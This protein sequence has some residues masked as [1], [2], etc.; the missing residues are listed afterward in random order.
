M[1][2]SEQSFF[3]L[4]GFTLKRRVEFYHQMMWWITCVFWVLQIFFWLVVSNMFYFSI[5]WECHHPNWRTHTFQRG[6][7]TTKQFWF[8]IFQQQDDIEMYWVHLKMVFL[9]CSILFLI[10]HGMDSRVFRQH[11]IDNPTRWCPRSIA[12]LVQITPISL[13]FIGDISIVSM[14]L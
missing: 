14:G 10:S 9:G 1:C 12:E 6:M 5:Y 13:W 8:G 4:M 3:F 2:C 7:S 11:P